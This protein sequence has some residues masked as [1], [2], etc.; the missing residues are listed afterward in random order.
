[1]LIPVFAGTPRPTFIFA[2]TENT[3]HYRRWFLLHLKQQ[4]A[5]CFSLPG[6][7]RNVRGTSTGRVPCF[8]LIAVYYSWT[9]AHNSYFVVAV[10]VAVVIAVAVVVLQL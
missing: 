4:G 7:E 8:I 9:L 1:M 5:Y 3:A 10:V 2:T 6:E